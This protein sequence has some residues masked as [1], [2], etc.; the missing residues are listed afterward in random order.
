MGLT[1]LAGNTPTWAKTLLDT[2]CMHGDLPADHLLQLQQCW[3]S[4]QQHG[5]GD[6]S[7]LSMRWG[8]NVV[9]YSRLPSPKNFPSERAGRASGARK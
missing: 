6:Y 5:G 1:S 8:N 3:G 9:G 2:D 7:S 4:P